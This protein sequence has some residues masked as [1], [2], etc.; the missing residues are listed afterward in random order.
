MWW[1]AICIKVLA[2]VATI[3]MAGSTSKDMEESEF[4]SHVQGCYT[5]ILFVLVVVAIWWKY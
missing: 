2:T 3:A 4:P 5:A 1:L